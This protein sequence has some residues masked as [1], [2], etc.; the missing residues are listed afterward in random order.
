ML[1]AFVCKRSGFLEVSGDM[2]SAFSSKLSVQ[3][4]SIRDSGLEVVL[5]E[6]CIVLRGK[7]VLNMKRVSY[8]LS[9]V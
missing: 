3:W 9:C 7:S 2:G 6:L 1:C 8:C 4:S 5:Q